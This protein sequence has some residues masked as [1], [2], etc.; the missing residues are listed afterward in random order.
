MS[1]LVAESA[2]RF[3]DPNVS[4]WSYNTPEGA[5][6]TPKNHAKAYYIK[7]YIWVFIARNKTIQKCFS[8]L[9]ATDTFFAPPLACAEKNAKRVCT[10]F[11]N[12]LKICDNILIFYEVIYILYFS[13]GI[14][15]VILSLLPLLPHD[16]IS[17]HMFKA[18][19][20]M[21]RP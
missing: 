10:S 9:W 3:R 21:I 19:N 20:I 17:Y 16:F 4:Q 13:S 2:T 5:K 11:L 1:P 8:S 7:I 18:N 14:L 15:K 6:R 12:K